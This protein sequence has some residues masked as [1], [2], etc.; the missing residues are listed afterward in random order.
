MAMFLASGLLLRRAV[1]RI[2][3]TPPGYQPR[4]TLRHLGR[5]VR[6]VRREHV[7]RRQNPVEW[8]TRRA[9]G[10]RYSD[11]KEISIAPLFVWFLLLG[12]TLI[13]GRPV[14]LPVCAV[15][16]LPTMVYGAR[17]LSDDRDNGMLELFLIT[18][19]TPHQ[20]ISGKL[21]GYRFFRRLNFSSG[22]FGAV[23]ALSLVLVA[24]PMP[25]NWFGLMP[26][27]VILLCP[28]F[29]VVAM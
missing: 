5:M 11:S 21:R 15:L 18:S 4:P 27:L 20:I 19:L 1:G 9:Q 8:I 16:L 22:M 3:R 12:V 28:V 25:G 17:A 14:F 13:M 26:L 10:E 29:A 2:G 6:R 7:G 24:V 23:V